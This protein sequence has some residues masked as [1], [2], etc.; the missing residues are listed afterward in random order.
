[1]R[2]EYIEV[3]SGEG[4]TCY[5]PRSKGDRGIC[6]TPLSVSGFVEAVS[7]SGVLGMDRHLGTR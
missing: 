2:I 7:R 6:R 4:L 3:V 1:M 5:L